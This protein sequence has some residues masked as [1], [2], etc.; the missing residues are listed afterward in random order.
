MGSISHLCIGDPMAVHAQY[1][2]IDQ[3]VEQRTD[4]ALLSKGD[5]DHV[6]NRLLVMTVSICLDRVG[7]QLTMEMASVR[8]MEAAMEDMMSRTDGWLSNDWRKVEE[9]NVV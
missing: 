3:L 6:R 9:R 8:K 1:I 5:S 2:V 4:G 7:V